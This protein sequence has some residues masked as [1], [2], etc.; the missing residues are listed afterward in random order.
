MSSGFFFT[1]WKM[2]PPSP[3]R[4]II[5]AIKMIIPFNRETVPPLDFS[6]S[7][8]HYNLCIVF[9]P[10]LNFPRIIRTEKVTC[11]QRHIETYDCMSWHVLRW[12]WLLGSVGLLSG[13]RKKKQQLMI[14]LSVKATNQ[15]EGRGGGWA[16][17]LDLDI[18]FHASSLT[19]H[20]CWP[21][22]KLWKPSFHD[23]NQVV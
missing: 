4:G 7:T 8:M 12:D 15:S 1:M 2:T 17:V 13:H 6:D 22:L 5:D 16:G 14:V 18:G 21:L 10:F 9:F 23:L 11:Q 20:Q 19:T 3:H